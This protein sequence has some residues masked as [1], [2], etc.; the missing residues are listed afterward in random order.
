MSAN[1]A[2][3]VTRYTK[4]DDLPELVRPDEAAAWLDLGRTAIYELIRRGELEHLRFGR[5]V[6]IPKFALSTRK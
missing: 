3:P 1:G 5:L 4:F 2:A 6:R